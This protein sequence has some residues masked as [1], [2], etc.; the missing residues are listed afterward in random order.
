MAVASIDPYKFDAKDA[1]ENFHG[2]QLVYLHWED[3]LMF[4]APVAFPLPAEMVFEDMVQNVL[5]PAYGQHPD[6]AKIIWSDVNWTLDGA[7]FDPE[8]KKSLADNGVGHKSLLKFVTPGLLGIG[9]KH[10]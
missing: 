6:F 4:C 9:G 10:F 3:H 1:V 2:N 8:L 5:S 7:S